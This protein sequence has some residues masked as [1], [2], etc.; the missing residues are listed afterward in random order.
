MARGLV[1]ETRQDVGRRGDCV[2]GED[3]LC[4]GDCVCVCVF[5]TLARCAC[6]ILEYI[7]FAL[8]VSIS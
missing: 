4:G 6:P 2:F 1:H 8:L 3:C 5:C 7:P